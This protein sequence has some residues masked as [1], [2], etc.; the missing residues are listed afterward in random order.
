MKMSCELLSF[1][2]SWAFCYMYLLM[3]LGNFLTGIRFLLSKTDKLNWPVVTV[4]VEETGH[5][6]NDKKRVSTCA[7]V[8][9]CRF[10]FGISYFLA[11]FF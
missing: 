1:V 5:P 7:E 4:N 11:D 8:C 2:L 9:V 6:L 3:Y 10:G